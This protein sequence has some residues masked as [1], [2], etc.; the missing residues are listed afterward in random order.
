MKVVYLKKGKV[1]HIVFDTTLD[2]DRVTVKNDSFKPI[3]SHMPYS[4]KLTESWYYCFC[5]MHWDVEW[6]R[7]I[8]LTLGKRTQV[9]GTIMTQHTVYDPWFLWRNEWAKIESYWL[10]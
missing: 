5:L 8:S 1:Q 2:K 7:E 3:N 6:C 9:F 10:E 4:N